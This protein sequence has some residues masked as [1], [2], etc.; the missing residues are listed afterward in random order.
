MKTTPFI[1]E[2]VEARLY[3]GESTL[4]GKTAKE[5]SAIVFLM[6]M[7][8]EIMRHESPNYAR[9][10]VENSLQFGNFDS[11]RSSMTDFG[12]LVAVLSNQD[13]YD[14]TIKA[15]FG[16]NIPFLQLKRYLTDIRNGAKTSSMDKSF[17]LKLEDFLKVSE[18]LHK[19]IRRHVTN[20][21]TLKDNEKNNVVE[22]IKREFNTRSN[23]NDIYLQLKSEPLSFK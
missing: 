6:I 13:D 5:I 22:I 7:T 14:D 15:D 19:T 1:Q 11:M 23:Y 9:K 20:W 4:K 10:Y 3:K 12:N 18:G 21:D 17:F 8:L 2:L 16:I